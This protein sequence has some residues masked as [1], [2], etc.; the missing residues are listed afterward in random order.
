ML[1]GL[2]AGG[3]AGG[4]APVLALIPLAA[5][6]LVF[7]VGARVRRPRAWVTVALMFAAAAGGTALAPA[8]EHPGRGGTRVIAGTIERCDA[9]GCTVRVD[10]LDGTP[11]RTRARLHG[12]TG[13]PGDRVTSTADLR[14][15]ARFRNP[16]PHPDW[17]SVEPIAWAG[18]VHES[19]ILRQPASAGRR[20]I[21][22]LRARIRAGIERTLEPPTRGLVLAL[23]LGDEADVDGASAASVRAAGLTHV[24][25]VSGMHVTLV[26]GALLH[27]LL[28]LLRR[29]AIAAY[30]DPTRIAH[31][32]AAPLALVYAEIA[33]GSPSAYRAATTAAISWWLR[34]AGRRPDAIGTS[35]LAALVFVAVDPASALRPAFVLSIAATAAV[36][37]MP[38]ELTLETLARGSTRASVATAPLVLWCFE[39]VP[40]VALAANVLLLP[41]VAALVLP[42]ATLHALLGAIDPDLASPSA[43]VLDGVCRGFVGACDALG[44][45]DAGRGLPPLDVAQGL[46]LTAAATALLVVRGARLRLA[47][48]AIAL[49]ALAGA[50]AS[51]RTRELP[52]G[53]LR[54]TFLDVGQGDA[55]LVDLPD[56]SL[57]V[58]DAG[59]AF[60]G[61][62]DPGARVLVPLLRARRRARIDR[63]VVTH[64]HPD[65]YGGVAALAARFPIDEVWDSGQALEEDPTGAWARALGGLGRRAR[66][67]DP[68]TLCDRPVVR[69]GARL[70]LLWPCPAF[71]PGW[72][73]NDNSIVLRI[74]YGTRSFLLMGD[75]E[76][77]AE[78]ALLARGL[79]GPV[80]VLK[81]GHHGSHTSSTDAFVAALAPRLAIVSA[82]VGNRFGHPHEDVMDRLA[83]RGIDVLRTDL[84]GGIVVHTDGHALG[85][86]AWSGARR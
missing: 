70:E 14:P 51:L 53:E 10:A 8:T 42:L 33:G 39:G 83:A 45:I 66:V 44:T 37:E 6:T 1:A 4:G 50:E 22:A 74:T 43:F 35:A 52:R 13:G 34:A 57:M 20:A 55:A 30:V 73:A 47:T 85:A 80:D 24:L 41:I 64:P 84:D 78:S 11:V 76:A 61:G 71:D 32:L 49:V 58:V 77:H 63:L 56:G 26:V 31:G 5:G 3:F 79:R 59:G 81:L 75:A 48:V 7:V 15:R 17:P 69:G 38:A 19:T 62:A 21:E 2:V 16:S 54:L 12:L 25:A 28:R 65:H 29:P 60:Q 18:R 40:L 72:D 67:E 46:V 27:A 36:V 82:G 86:E 23:V 68:R 9:G